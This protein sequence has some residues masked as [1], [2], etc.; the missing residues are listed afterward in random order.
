M[1][2]K[3]HSCSAATPRWWAISCWV[4]EGRRNT[5]EAMFTFASPVR[6]KKKPVKSR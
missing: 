2:T 4:V 3:L 6:G 1:A 5:G